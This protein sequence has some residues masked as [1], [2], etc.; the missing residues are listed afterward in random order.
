MQK[1]LLAAA[2]ALTLSTVSL[3]AAAASDGAFVRLEGG[4]AHYD[5][6]SRLYDGKS[7]RAFSIGGGYRWQVAPPFALGVEAGFVDLGKVK[8]RM[9]GTFF[10]SN[11]TQQPFRT[12]SQLGTRALLIG[13]NGRWEIAKEWSVTGRFGMAHTHTKLW[14]QTDAGR[15][16]DY[17]RGTNVRNTAYFGAGVNYAIS[18]NIDAGIHMTHY[19]SVGTG[20]A[21]YNKRVDI[22]AFGAVVE[23]RF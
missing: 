20:F 11:G 4:K 3:A 6:D 15:A 17:Y 9:R 10:Y 19:S 12:H 22:N 5:V 1:A 2:A 13:A 7:A 16:S 14:S 23:A 21:A 8:H 18:P